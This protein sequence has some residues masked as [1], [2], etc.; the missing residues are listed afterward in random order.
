MKKIKKLDF[1]RMELDHKV[2]QIFKES[3]E[4]PKGW[5]SDLILDIEYDRQYIRILTAFGGPTEWYTINTQKLTG[6]YFY[7]WQSYKRQI[8]LNKKQ[9]RTI[10]QM[11]NEHEKRMRV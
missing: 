5:I 6:R 1:E 8:T 2:A 7:H 11:V 10:L 9:V 3:M 4:D